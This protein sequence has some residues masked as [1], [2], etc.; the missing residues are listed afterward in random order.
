MIK[1]EENLCKTFHGGLCDLK[2]VPKSI[3]HISHDI[4]KKHDPCLLEINR[5]YIGLVEC[6]AEEIDCF[7]LRPSKQKLALQK[8]PAAINALNGTLPC[9]RTLE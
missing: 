1:F 2:S 4:G 7:Y 9:A 8:N 3:K 6:K 5:S